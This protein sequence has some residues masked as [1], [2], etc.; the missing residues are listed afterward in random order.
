MITRFSLTGSSP[1]YSYLSQVYI[2]NVV[3]AGLTG[4]GNSYTM[5]GPELAE[6]VMCNP[7]EYFSLPPWMIWW[8]TLSWW[9]P[10]DDPTAWYLMATLI[11]RTDPIRLT[12]QYRMLV[13][14]LTPPA[15]PDWDPIT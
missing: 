2:D 7:M 6:A 3:P 5:T 13:N 11:D 4:D 14:A 8:S 1:P 12:S 9:F 15:R 10:E